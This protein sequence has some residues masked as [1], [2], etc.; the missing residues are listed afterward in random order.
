MYDKTL[1]YLMRK[2]DSRRG[3]RDYAMDE[4]RRRMRRD[5]EMDEARRRRDYAEYDEARRRRRDYMEYD[6]RSDYMDYADYDHV[7]KEYE[8]DLEHWT[9]KLKHKDRF[10]L[11]K[12]EV[13]NKAKT[14]GAKFHEY[15]EEEFYAV[16]LMMV[17][18]YSI[19]NEPH[20]YLAMAKQF[21][22]DDDIPMSGSEK[23]CKYLYEIV[24]ND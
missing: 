3:R 19:A 11:P 23:V 24:L 18:D 5:Y 22:E 20:T 21:L 15:S 10:N 12:H 2:R 13:I 7:K 6:R 9:H 14:M 4:A 1:D 17:S 16:Y 8:E